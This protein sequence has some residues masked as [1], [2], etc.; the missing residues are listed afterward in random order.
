MSRIFKKP[1]KGSGTVSSGNAASTAAAATDLSEAGTHGRTFCTGG[2]D[3]SGV[4]LSETERTREAEEALSAIMMEGPK[5]EGTPWYNDFVLAMRQSADKEYF[6]EGILMQWGW[7]KSPGAAED[8]NE[9]GAYL[10]RL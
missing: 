5:I 1:Q 10:L 9:Q 7:S 3:H 2:S 4:T 6:E 8:D